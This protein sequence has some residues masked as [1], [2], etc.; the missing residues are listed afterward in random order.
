MR[1]LTILLSLAFCFQP[2]AKT[3]KPLIWDMRNLEQMRKHSLD[4]EVV[5]QIKH[6]ADIYCNE[7]P[8]VIVGDKYLDFAP[9]DHYFC[10]MGPYRWP[11]PKHPGQY[12]WKDG[13]VNPESKFYDSRK[14]A[15]LSER[16]I[17]LSKA[18]Y[19][20][21]ENKYYQA[22][23]IQLR[24][25]FIDE[26][27][28]MYPNFEYSQVVP[29]QNNNKGTSTGMITAYDF[30]DIIESIRLV[31]CVKKIDNSTMNSLKNWF[32]SF[33][34]WSE[35]EY[36]SLFQRTNNN[37]SLAFDISLI[38]MF[39]FS[40]EEERAKE[41]ADGFEKRRILIQI[42]EDGRQPAE[43]LRTRAFEYSVLNLGHII[44]FC[45]LMKYWNVDYYLQN[46]ERI[47]KAFDYLLKYVDDQNSFP[48]KQITNWPT[49]VKI[50]NK[51]IQR[52]NLLKNN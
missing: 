35:S 47:D 19:L 43:L 24:S 3:Q 38:N 44:D 31:N 52:R 17:T 28:Y 18:F 22:Y 23:L 42:E 48:Y 30:N 26:Q 13:E 7:P 14:L 50:L 51:Q 6:K 29:G 15:E 11:D 21:K 27:T 39:L 2:C 1:L 32:L 33:A 12:I 45:F 8:V 41:I 46:G 9:N 49:C 36:G 37:I 5:N 34:N 25:W 40:G 16:C 4:K 10:S 20:Y